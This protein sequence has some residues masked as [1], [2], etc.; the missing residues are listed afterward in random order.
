MPPN[1]Y[2][3]PAL[4]EAIARLRRDLREPACRAR[5]ER[6]ARQGGK[7]GREHI[8][9]RLREDATAKIAE[10]ADWLEQ[11]DATGKADNSDDFVSKDGRLSN[12]LDSP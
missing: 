4:M 7:E 10:V 8:I 9:Q 6:M 12:P 1:K 11:A 5:A 3:S 2:P